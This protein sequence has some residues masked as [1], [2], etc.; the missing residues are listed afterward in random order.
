[1]LGKFAQHT[2]SGTSRVTANCRLAAIMVT[3]L[4][5]YSRVMEADEAG[6][7]DSHDEC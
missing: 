7:A 1:M 4:M 6:R 2:Q 5:G 3:D